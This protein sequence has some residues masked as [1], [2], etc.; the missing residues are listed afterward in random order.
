MI[1][2]PLSLINT[3][4]KVPFTSVQ[5]NSESQKAKTDSF[6]P[7]QNKTLILGQLPKDIKIDIS[8]ISASSE[9]VTA[10]NSTGY[11]AQIFKYKSSIFSKTYAIKKV[12]PKDMAK[13]ITANPTEQLATEA[14]VY[15]KLKGV[16][17]IPEFYFYKGD[18][19]NNSNAIDNNYLVMSWVDGESASN[20]GTFYNLGLIDNK[21]LEKIFSLLSK[22]DEKGILHNDLWAGNILFTK[23]DVNIIDFNRSVLFDPLKE[24]EKSNLESFKE[25]F[26]WRYLSDVYKQKGEGESVNIYKYICNLEQ[27]LLLQRA[28]LL[29]SNGQEEDAKRLE[30]K[31]AN[32]RLRI[33]DPKLMKQETID[34]IYKSDLRCSKIYAK[35]FEFEDGESLEC[36]NRIRTLTDKNPQINA[37]PK[38]I[39]SNIKIIRMF[40]LAMKQTEKNNFTDSLKL[41]EKIL[42]KLEDENSYGS[43]EKEEIYYKKFTEFTKLNIKILTALNANNKL[44]AKNILETNKEFFYQTKR[45]IP[46]YNKLSALIQ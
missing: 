10:T 26:L 22:F 42:K 1:S 27:N 20:N 6:T 11:L 12:W 8:K 39:D 41:Y 44:E 33:N 16:K 25:R 23:N 28:N 15:E 45:L 43:E 18:F 24:P 40:K 32:I 9:G 5:K 30:S 34:T 36:Y 29:L 4:S 37:N 14:K 17:N 46:Y 38:N 2:L 21:K 13:H 35:Y 19:S 3:K 31:S 7:A